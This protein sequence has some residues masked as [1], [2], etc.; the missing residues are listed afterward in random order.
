LLFESKH[1]KFFNNNNNINFNKFTHEIAY[2]CICN[3]ERG[4]I[5]YATAQGLWRHYPGCC[6]WRRWHMT[7]RRLHGVLLGPLLGHLDVLAVVALEDARD[8][9]HQRVVGVGVAQERTDRQQNLADGESRRP[10]GSEYV[11]ADATVRVY[12]RMVDLSCEAHL[13][14]LEWIVSGEVNSEKENTPLKWWIIRPHY[15]CLPMKKIISDRPGAALW[16]W[17]AIDV[18]HFLLYTLHSHLDILW[19]ILTIK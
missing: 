8:L 14:R 9:G 16:W 19:S 18:C 7:S 2:Y 3:H 5:N 11:Q 12:I 17:V 1:M 10:L 15:G 4:K 6:A 13:W